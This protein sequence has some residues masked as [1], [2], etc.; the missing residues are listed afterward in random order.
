MLNAYGPAK[1]VKMA[2]TDVWRHFA[3]P[4]KSGALYMTELV[5]VNPERRG[6][7]ID[8]WLHAVKVFCEYQQEAGTRKHNEAL[9]ETKKCS[10]LY[11][12][13]DRILPSL[14]YCLA[15]Q[16]QRAKEGASSLRSSGM[17]TNAGGTGT[18]DTE[19]NRHGKKDI[20]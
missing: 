1:F 11:E 4:L 8:R 3:T 16:K 19:L 14:A 13:I 17:E 12:E 7:G 2:D 15:P 9:L 6:V 20:V 18:D 5:S 10:E